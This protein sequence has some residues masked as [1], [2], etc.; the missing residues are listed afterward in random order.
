MHTKTSSQKSIEIIFIHLFENKKEIKAQSPLALYISF[1][2]P[3]FKCYADTYLTD[4]GAMTC[5]SGKNVVTRIRN[6][7]IQFS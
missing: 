7:I 6:V 2:F 3:M 4:Y 1:S 5:I